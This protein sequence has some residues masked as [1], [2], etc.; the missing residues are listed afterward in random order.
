VEDLLVANPNH[1]LGLASGSEGLIT[2]EDED[3]E[4]VELIFRR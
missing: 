1:A 2:S 3:D 4:K